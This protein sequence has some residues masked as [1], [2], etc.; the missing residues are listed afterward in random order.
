[1]LL[2]NKIS[3]L[4]SDLSFNKDISKLSG[5]LVN[6]IEVSENYQKKNSK[7]DR[8]DEF[9]YVRIKG[10]DFEGIVDGRNVF[11]IMESKQNVVLENVSQ[12]D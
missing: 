7:D 5:Q 3:L 12:L 4:N 8:C 11:E 1:M 9:L 10:K 2:G 6:V